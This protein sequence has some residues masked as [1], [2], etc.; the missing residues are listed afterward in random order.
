MKITF[1]NSGY[2]EG[3]LIECAD[4]SEEKESFRMTVDGGGAREEEFADSTS[5]R[6]PMAEY[7][8]KRGIRQIDLMVS[9]HTHEDHICGQK[10]CAEAFPPKELW[11]TLPPEQYRSFCELDPVRGTNLS[12]KNFLA[13]LNDYRSLCSIT[14]KNGGV[15]RQICAGYTCT[16]CESLKITVLG[17]DSVREE[18]L[19]C[20][21]Q[22]LYEA[23][24]SEDFSEK[25]DRVD[26][27]LNNFSLIL[28]LEYRGKRILLPG[29]TNRN[30]FSR[31]TAE[32]L[33]ADLFKV[34]HHGQID[35]ASEELMKKVQPS[36][37]VCCASSDRRYNSAHPE[38][39]RMIESGGA[40]MY[41]SDCPIEGLEPHC[42]V[43]FSLSD[44]G[45]WTVSYESMNN[46]KNS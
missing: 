45:E 30:G 26:G 6:I 40:R 4:V 17:P 41:Y 34:G 16:P 12:Q 43:S 14:E 44:Q 23:R 8:K 35:G 37:V 42:A 15:I 1:V 22:E 36:M 46:S 7:L 25:L 11:Q 9:T 32:E 21:M 18:E 13:A 2:A 31:L 24:G 27:R 3:I 28:L 29:D 33:R 5:G 20:M 19:S 38:L 39:I 10:R